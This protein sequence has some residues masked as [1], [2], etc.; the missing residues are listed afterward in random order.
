MWRCRVLPLQVDL[1][2]ATWLADTKVPF[3]LVFTKADKRKR[4]A[5]SAGVEGAA[6]PVGPSP[7][8]RSDGDAGGEES[9]EGTNW[10]AGLSAG[11][12]ANI[13]AF[14]RAL[15]ESC[16]LSAVPP[17]V[18]TSAADGTGKTQLLHFLAS[19]R[20]AFEQS[21]QLKK[22]ALR[23]QPGRPSVRA[24]ARGLLKRSVVK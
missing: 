18:I 3:A 6:A 23:A 10:R 16:G 4:A 13:S 21:G 7:S 1:D 8:A 15:L 12:V 20:I 17:S 5:A 19:L 2:Y 14:K 22:A 9:E 11:T 24:G